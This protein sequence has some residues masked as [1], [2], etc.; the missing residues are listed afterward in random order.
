M[1]KS[2]VALTGAF[3][4]ALGTLHAQSIIEKDTTR[5][6]GLSVQV[7]G[8]YAGEEVAPFWMRSNQFGSVPLDGGS[9]S[10]LL[11]GFKEYN[12][13]GEWK[14]R[15]ANDNKLWDW[16]YG[17]EARANVGHK[18]QGQLIDAHAKV[19]FAMFEARLGRSKDVMGLN[20]DTLLTSGNFAVSGNALGVPKFEISIPEYYRLPWFEGLLSFKGNFANGYMGRHELKPSSFRVPTD[21]YS[22]PTYMHQKSL[23]GRLGREDWKLQLFGGFN[24]QV[25]WGGE[26]DRYGRDFDLNFFQTLSYV[27]LGTAYGGQGNPI[28]RSKI[29]NHQ[30]SVDIGASYN[31]GPVTLMAY[32]QNFY[33]V[34]ALSKLAN[35]RDGLNGVTL[36]NNQY[37]TTKKDWDWRSLLFE[38][39]YSKDQAGYPWSKPTASGDEDYYNNSEY[40]EGW[41]YKDAGMGSPLIITGHTARPGQALFPHDFFIS[42]RVVAAH[43]GA[44]G[45]IKDW[46]VITKITYAKHYGT[47]ATS[48]YGK[49]TG[50][51]FHQPHSEMF[52]PVSQFSA[53]VQTEKQF[54][55]NTWIGGMFAI[56]QG[57]MLRSGSGLLLHVRR[58]F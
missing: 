30:G 3:S 34:G 17:L 9:G 15:E 20:G 50:R 6:S 31:F 51:T 14:G 40:L 33:D 55:S 38:F 22:V 47:F 28:P 24:H 23:Y 37:R 25:Q 41:S 8:G 19:R 45:H 16:G 35:I 18:F 46:N 1:K 54:F 43:V 39:F 4:I 11:R 21:D 44:S 27:T 5:R 7:M 10:V 36:T 52:V 13:P 58:E 57:K 49:S 29:G 26:A 56:D 12:Q 2:I 48:E 32:R 42:N 53:F